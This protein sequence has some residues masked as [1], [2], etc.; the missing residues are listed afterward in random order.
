MMQAE[1]TPVVDDFITHAQG[2]S[3][4]EYTYVTATDYYVSQS[5][6]DS[7]SAYQVG[8]AGYGT[9]GQLDPRS[10]QAWQC[11]GSA[12]GYMPNHCVEFPFGDPK[13][14]DDWYDVTNLHSLR[15][16]LGAGS[17]GAT[18]TQAIVLQQLR[19]Y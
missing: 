18:G 8:G 14:P 9:G 10:T 2:T 7:G 6:T 15:A 19:K 12:R 4:G 17:G 11:Q 1:W 13:D 3:G 5:F 16:R